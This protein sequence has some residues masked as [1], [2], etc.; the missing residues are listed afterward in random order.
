MSTIFLRKGMVWVPGFSIRTVGLDFGPAALQRRYEAIAGFT[1]TDSTTERELGSFMHFRGGLSVLVHC[2]QS[3]SLQIYRGSIYQEEAIGILVNRHYKDAT[4]P[5][6]RT[7][8]QLALNLS[9]I[10][11]FFPLHWRFKCI[12]GRGTKQRAPLLPTRSFRC[13]FT[14]LRSRNIETQRR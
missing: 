4:A 3:C 10:Y 8:P 7:S 11:L 9:D 12:P 2:S 6:T 5:I 13:L 14:R 1:S